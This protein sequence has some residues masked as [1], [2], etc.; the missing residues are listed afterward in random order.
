MALAGR[1]AGAASEGGADRPG[2]EVTTGED[3][4]HF[5]DGRKMEAA[6]RMG[7]IN[8]R[9]DAVD[10]TSAGVKRAA[11]QPDEGQRGHIK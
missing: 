9:L 5:P 6:C 2:R 4:K 10:H 1:L 11:E 3:R 7:S 8:E